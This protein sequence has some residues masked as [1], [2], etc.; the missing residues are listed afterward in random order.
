MDMIL[1]AISDV[2]LPMNILW[3][4]G[5]TA[6]GIVAGVLP[7][8]GASLTMALLI[9]VTFYL[10]KTTG[11]MTLVSAWAGAVYGGS[12][13]SILI[14]T[15][16]TGANVA[17][18]FDGFPMARDGKARVALGISAT[19][20]MIGGL[21]GIIVLILFSP[22]ISKISV[23]FGAA[24]YF[25]LAIFGL[26]VTSSTIKGSTLKGLI[27]SGVGL[28]ISF[29][30]YDIITGT[31]RYTFHTMYLEDGIDFLIV[32]IGFF[33]VT[34]LFSF[35][36]EKGSISLAGKI[37]GKIS[38]GRLLL[39]ISVSDTG[40]GV[41]KENIPYLFDSFSRVGEFS[42]G[43]IEGTG[44]GLTITKPVRLTNRAGS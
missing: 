37:E 32:V 42:H 6:L 31:K 43:R 29:I 5:G 14:N 2:L 9:P 22:Y 3:F 17:T 33:A 10:D 26:T 44:L 41:A 23:M 38:E 1:S 11:L 7:G 13:S 36:S 27:S 40:I 18:C 8:V 4:L 12:I 24:E 21:F 39:I 30:G 25:L 20:S 34:Q 16:G 19:S 35:L 28:M 15:P